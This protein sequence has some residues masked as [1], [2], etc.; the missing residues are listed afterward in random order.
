[1]NPDSL[2]PLWVLALAF[3]AVAV[4]YAIFALAGFGAIFITGPVL[5][6]VMPEKSQAILARSA[7]YAENRLICGVHYRSDV[8]AGE[9]IGTVIGQDMLHSP[10]F[11]ADLEAARAELKAAGL[12]AP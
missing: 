6:Q 1:M 5:A 3:P 11:R 12:S 2:P 10:A 7:E 9:A 4:A 8:A